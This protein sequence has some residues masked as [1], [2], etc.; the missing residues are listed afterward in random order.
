M[1]VLV[2]GSLTP[3]SP[4]RSSRSPFETRGST[5]GP[6]LP[7]SLSPPSLPPPFLPARRYSRRQARIYSP[8]R[9]LQ[10]RKTNFLLRGL[11]E[12]GP[13]GGS[14]PELNFARLKR[15]KW[16]GPPQLHL[17]QPPLAEAPMC[18]QPFQARCLRHLPRRSCL[19]GR[20]RI[21]RLALASSSEGSA[22]MMRRNCTPYRLL[23]DTIDWYIH[24]SCGLV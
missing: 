7:P 20:R 12:H 19:R 8:K 2:I 10:P 4:R 18:L 5:K 21:R 6:P 23:P 15:P 17:L 24:G 9:H 16:S 1:T 11:K 22:C 14:R 3:D 13:L